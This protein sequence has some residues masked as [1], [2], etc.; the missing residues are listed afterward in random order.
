MTSVLD[1]VRYADFTN[2]G[3]E[4][5]ATPLR[6]DKRSVRTFADDVVNAEFI[7]STPFRLIV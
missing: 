1:W 6:N 2:I 5:C 3:V 7:T 4:F